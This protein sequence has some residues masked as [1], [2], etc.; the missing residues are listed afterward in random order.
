ML[1][2]LQA[3]ATFFA[4]PPLG[5]EGG[6]MGPPWAPQWAPH[7]PPNWG[8]WDHTGPWGEMRKMLRALQRAQH[9]SLPPRPQIWAPGPKIDPREPRGA[10]IIRVPYQGPP[11]IFRRRR[12]VLQVN[13]FVFKAD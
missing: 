6:A 2:A 5:P 8:P 10:K 4:I 7:G 11:V 1:R 9:F 12:T 3:R 13:K